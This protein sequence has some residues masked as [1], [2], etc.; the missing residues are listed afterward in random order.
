MSVQLIGRFECRNGSA[1]PGVRKQKGLQHLVRAVGDEDLRRR[2]TMQRSDRLAKVGSCPI[3]IPIP[4]ETR[5]FGCEGIAPRGRW[6]RWGLVRVE[7]NPHRHLG[8]VIPLHRLEI[9][10][11]GNAHHRWQAS[12]RISRVANEFGRVR[13]ADEPFCCNRNQRCVRWA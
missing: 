4:L 5:H 12:D 1:R 11:N 3:W 13:L 6:G 9:V 7:P 8:R 2:N 10:S